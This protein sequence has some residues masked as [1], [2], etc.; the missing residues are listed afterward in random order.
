MENF[1]SFE[2]ETQEMIIGGDHVKTHYTTAN[3]GS[4]SDIYDTTAETIVYL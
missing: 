2:I 3:G 1:K 4:G